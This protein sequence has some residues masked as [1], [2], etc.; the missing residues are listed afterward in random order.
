MSKV[1]VPGFFL[2]SCERSWIYCPVPGVPLCVATSDFQNC[3]VGIVLLAE[4]TTLKGSCVKFWSCEE[5]GN[6]SSYKIYKN[7]AFICVETKFKS[8]ER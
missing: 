8:N 3:S 2:P 5:L 4:H 1:L 6:V 7:L